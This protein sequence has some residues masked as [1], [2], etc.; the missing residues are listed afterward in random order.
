[1]EQLFRHYYFFRDIY[2]THNVIRHN[3][4]T[5]VTILNPGLIIMIALPPIVFLAAIKTKGAKG[6]LSA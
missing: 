1:M 2:S 6:Y 4:Y 5:E 3:N